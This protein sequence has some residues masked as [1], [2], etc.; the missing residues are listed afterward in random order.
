MAP[1]KITSQS[2]IRNILSGGGVD[3]MRSSASIA[4][5]ELTLDSA[6]RKTVQFI[7]IS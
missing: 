4:F 2:A 5:G 3:E 7:S 1:K 6:G